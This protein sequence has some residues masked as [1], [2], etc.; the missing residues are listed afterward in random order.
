M[1]PLSHHL[2][3]IFG[4]DQDSVLENHE[5]TVSTGGRTIISFDDDIDGSAG[6]EEE[7]TKLV[8]RLDNIFTAY[9]I[10]ISAEKIK[11][12]TNKTCPVA[13]MQRLR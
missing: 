10:E 4:K 7:R 12:M 11:L 13:S 9:G 6:E 1:C 2:Q 5:G 3:H 8:E